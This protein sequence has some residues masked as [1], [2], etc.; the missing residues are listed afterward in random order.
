MYIYIYIYGCLQVLGRV[1][2]RPGASELRPISLLT[3]PLLTLL[4]SKLPDVSLWA[5]E[6][7]PFKLR[8]CLSQTL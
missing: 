5:W 2:E 3:L 1:S 6:F 4:D 8:L 7:H